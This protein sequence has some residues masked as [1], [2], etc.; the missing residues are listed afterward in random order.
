MPLP[1]PIAPT[2]LQRRRNHRLLFAQPDASIV[3]D[4]MKCLKANALHLVRNAAGAMAVITLSVCESQV[5][6]L[7]STILVLRTASLCLSGSTQSTVAGQN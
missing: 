3:V 6:K 2:V 5:E 7:M 1:R 4:N